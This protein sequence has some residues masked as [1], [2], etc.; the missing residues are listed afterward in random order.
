MYTLKIIL[1]C[2]VIDF[3]VC[4]LRFITNVCTRIY[5]CTTKYNT[6]KF[7]SLREKVEEIKEIY[8]R[9]YHDIKHRDDGKRIFYKTRDFPEI[10]NILDKIPG[11]KEDSGIICVMNFPMNVRPPRTHNNRWLR[12]ELVLRGGKGC[13]LDAR[14]G[15]RIIISDGCDT[16]FDP[17]RYHKYIKRSVFT[18]LS[19]VFDVD[20]F[21]L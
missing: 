8:Y 18:R 3:L 14:G 13:I 10:Q 12:Y 21:T 15:E 1:L 2:I 17:S 16:I 20:R 19:L 4:H 11:I 6:E 9:E 5:T 7:K